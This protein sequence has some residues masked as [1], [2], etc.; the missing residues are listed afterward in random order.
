MRLMPKVTAAADR[1]KEIAGVDLT[2][3]RG[4]DEKTILTILSE[5]GTD[6]SK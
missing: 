1:L 4:L 6:L 2:K 3:I 5:T